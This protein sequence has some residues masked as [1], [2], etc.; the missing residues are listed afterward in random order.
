VLRVGEWVFVTDAILP[1]AVSTFPSSG[2]QLDCPDSIDS[3]LLTDPGQIARE[4]GCTA[5]TL[6]LWMRQAERDEGTRSDGLTT[7]EREE[8]RQLKRENRILREER[9]IL[10]K[11]G[12]TG[13]GARHPCGMRIPGSSGDAGAA[14]CCEPG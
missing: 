9:E 5:E 1:A 10:V 8:L 12:M 14:W 6:R 13:A 3:N 7:A 2:V 11:V 4:L